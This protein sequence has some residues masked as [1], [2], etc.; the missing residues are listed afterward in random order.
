MFGFFSKRNIVASGILSSMID[1]HSHILYGVDDGAQKAESSKAIFD[2]YK[3]MGITKIFCTPHIKLSMP[4]NDPQ[5]LK[6]KFELF[7]IEFPNM[8]MRLAAEYMLD[9]CFSHM[10]EDKEILSYDGEHVLVELYRRNTLEEIYDKLFGIVV[11]GYTP[12]LA[13][14]E[15]YLSFSMRDL[16]TIK[17]RGVLFQLNMP[18]LTDYYGEVV[19]RRSKEFF[20]ADIYDFVATDFHDV[21]QMYHILSLTTGRKDRKRF[22][23]L[24]DNNRSLWI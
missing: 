19:G 24:I 1:I 4:D 9:E 6:Q 8:E 2:V 23:K 15:R 7:K 3:E 5:S 16:L 13:H 20:D 10:T 22:E 18:S 11:K 14:P 12:V 17:D 21:S